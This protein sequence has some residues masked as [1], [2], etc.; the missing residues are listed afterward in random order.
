MTEPE[1]AVQGPRVKDEPLSVP[2]PKRDRA[3]EVAALKRDAVTLAELAQ[4][5]P[6][7]IEQA[8]KGVRPKGLLE[9]LKLIEK[10]SRH[11]RHELSQ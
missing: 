9:N 6:Q 8:Q 11:L 3:A 5:V 2:Q 10:L 4:T 7:G 1:I